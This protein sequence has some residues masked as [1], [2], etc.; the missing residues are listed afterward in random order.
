MLSLLF[1]VSLKMI[2]PDVDVGSRT[3]IFN[4]PDGFV[5]VPD[6]EHELKRTFEA[7]LLA[8]LSITVVPSHIFMKKFAAAATSLNVTF[9]LTNH[10]PIPPTLTDGPSKYVDTLD[11]F[12]SAPK[13]FDK[14]DGFVEAGSE[15]G[16]HA[17]PLLIKTVPLAIG[18]TPV[19]DPAVITTTDEFANVV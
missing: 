14:G 18:N 6:N 7:T 13:E 2:C 12:T 3:D 8:A 11:K 5:I 4:A 17:V 19:M 10:V 9:P 1:P 15:F 16:P